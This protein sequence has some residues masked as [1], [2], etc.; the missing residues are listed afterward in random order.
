M[1]NDCI[2]EKKR[3]IICARAGNWARKNKNVV[4]TRENILDNYIR[5]VKSESKKKLMQQTVVNV[6][7]KKLTTNKTWKQSIDKNK[8]KI[9]KRIKHLVETKK[10][11]L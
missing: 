7:P 8:K 9:E 11:T 2:G 4:T 1:Y 5:K 3:E 6:K 10:N